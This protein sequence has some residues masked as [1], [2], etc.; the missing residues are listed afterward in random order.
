MHDTGKRVGRK[1]KR[2]GGE[3]VLSLSGSLS[4]TEMKGLLFNTLT[5]MLRI[6]PR[7]WTNFS[8]SRALGRME[9]LSS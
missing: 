8:W 7:A 5:G 4:L 1:R 9:A 2:Q 6:F 3:S